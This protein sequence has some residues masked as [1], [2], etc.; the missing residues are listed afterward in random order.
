MQPE[1]IVAVTFTEAAAAELK[2]RIGAKLLAM[3]RVEDALRLEQAYI[4][5]IHG[6]GLRLL[7]EFA[8]ESGSSPQPRLL[9]ED[10]QNAL[11]RLAAA[12][13][14]RGERDH[15]E[16]GGVR[17]PLRVRCP[18]RGRRTCSGTICSRSWRLLRSVGWRSYSERVCRAGGR[19]DRRALRADR[20][21]RAVE[22]GA[23]RECRGAARGSFRD[24]LA[25]EYGTNETAAK[26]LQKDFGNL[27]AA[28]QGRRARVGLGAV[29]EA[30]GAAAV[31]AGFGAAGA[32]RRAVVGRDDGRECAA[33]R[34]RGRSRT[35][36]GTSRRCSRPGRKC[37]CTTSRRSARRGSSTTAT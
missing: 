37:W 32:L 28:L 27:N 16:P 20:G 34:I 35:R 24:N 30:A 10:E 6:F 11:I 9:N 18:R 3:G 26:A 33:A 13:T 4:S 19:V 22:R 7:T 1:R 17:L 25:P 21:R 5:T 31:E 15:R 14:E 29:A 12:R 8:F 36:G 2:E 23:R